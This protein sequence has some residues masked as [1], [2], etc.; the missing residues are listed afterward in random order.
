M[1]TTMRAHQISDDALTIDSLT[2]HFAK[3]APTDFDSQNRICGSLDL[4]LSPDGRSLA[5]ELS[6]EW[7]VAQFDIIYSATCSAAKETA[8]AIVKNQKCRLKTIDCW[9]NL[10]H[11]LW[12]G[13]CRNEIKESAPRFYRQWQESP[14]TIAP[15]EG[16]T[17]EAVKRR[18]QASV[19]KI[20]NKW[21]HR[22][23]EILIVA[24][25]PLLQILFELFQEQC[26]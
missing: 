14:G 3:S 25:D 24:P 8:A 26:D 4:P 6:E 19:R 18:C 20:S 2:V 11:G 15:P 13:K 1:S 5:T 17:F 9:K 12:H 22:H 16:E 10:D 21:R 7:A 23:A